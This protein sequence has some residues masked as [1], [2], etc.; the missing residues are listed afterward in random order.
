MGS[1]VTLYRASV[2]LIEIGRVATLKEL[3]MGKIR[4][5]GN[6]NGG[7]KWIF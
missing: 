2:A 7:L 5:E 3:M 1:L 4:G 6:F